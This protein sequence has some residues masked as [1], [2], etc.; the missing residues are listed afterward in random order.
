[1]RRRLLE[2]LWPTAN[3]TEG[4]RYALN[5]LRALVIVLVV[6]VLV[7]GT[8][9]L[10]ESG[11]VEAKVTGTTASMCTFF[12]DL[13]ESPIPPNAQPLGVKIV[14]DSREIFRGLRCPGRLGPPSP[15]L[16]ELAGR[17]RIPLEG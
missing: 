3:M 11:R 8:R 10:T 16:R 7:L 9:S 14:V 17:Y 12:R 4:A 5:T 2:V 15:K 6:A 1:M 13:G